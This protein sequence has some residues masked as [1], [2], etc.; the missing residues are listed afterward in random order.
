MVFA[1]LV[2]GLLQTSS[3]E[4]LAKLTYRTVDAILKG[5]A[6]PEPTTKNPPKGV[7]VTIESSGK[8]L[9]CRGTLEPSEA[10]LEL[11]IQKSAQSAAIFDPRY[12]G[13]HIGNKPFAVTLT[14]VD[15]FESI[16]S[17]ATLL[18]QEGLILRSKTGVGIVL[19]WEGKDPNIRLEW[20][21]T[22]AKTPRADP[23]QLERLYAQRYRY[24][25]LK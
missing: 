11:E 15:H 23:V 2:A 25:E 7:F 24:P 20:A 8:V 1:V 17:V 22:K 13:V 16:G 19:P 6:L 10:T 21:Y 5:S 4:S 12:H 14:I 18:P 3:P 9:G